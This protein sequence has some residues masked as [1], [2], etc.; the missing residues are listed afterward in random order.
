MKNSEIM[1]S[2]NLLNQYNIRVGIDLIFG[3]PGET[4]EQAFETIEFARK[5]NCDGINSNV[6]M[7]YP[8]TA[9][10]DYSI[11]KGYLSH[12]VSIDEVESLHPNMSQLQ[13]DNINKLINL[14]KLCHLAIRHPKLQW[15]VKLLIK[16]PPNKLFLIIKDIPSIQRNFKYE[17]KNYKG[18]L[19]FLINYS[20]GVM[21]E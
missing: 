2:C 3:W 5:L 10:T 4:I 19:I 16:L 18:R 13:Q 21:K 15:L 14:D 12:E 7:Y 17:I 8:K 20:K 11:K 6:L 1:D 9:I